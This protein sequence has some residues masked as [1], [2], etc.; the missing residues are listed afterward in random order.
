MMDAVKVG[1]QM[2]WHEAHPRALHME[3][4]RNVAKKG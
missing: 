2:N 1:R 4:G 3:A